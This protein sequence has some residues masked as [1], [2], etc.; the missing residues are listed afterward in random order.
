MDEE[1]GKTGEKDSYFRGMQQYLRE[2]QHVIAQFYQENRELK[3][4]L[5]EKDFEEQTTQ[6]KE[7]PKN[8]SSKGK[9]VMQIPETIVLA[10]PTSHLTRSSTRNKSPY[11]QSKL[12]TSE[13]PPTSPTEGEKNIRW[14]NK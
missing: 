4:K 8:E 7:E 13:R 10:K 14:L 3:R 6:N 11:I 5:A 1:Q 9:E 2:A 12:T